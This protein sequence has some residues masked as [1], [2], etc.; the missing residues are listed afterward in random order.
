MK[1]DLDDGAPVNADSV[2]DV[3]QILDQC[4]RNIQGEANFPSGPGYFGLGHVDEIV[5]VLPGIKT[6]VKLFTI[7]RE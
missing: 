3:I 5:D 1:P 7:L 4:L 2:S 6:A